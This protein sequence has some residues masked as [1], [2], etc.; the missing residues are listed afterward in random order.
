MKL[1]N[2]IFSNKYY[3]HTHARAHSLNFSIG[4]QDCSKFYYFVEIVHCAEYTDKK[5][6]R[7]HTCACHQLLM[8]LLRLKSFWF[9]NSKLRWRWHDDRYRF[10][11]PF[12]NN[13]TKKKPQLTFFFDKF[14]EI[15]A[16]RPSNTAHCSIFVHFG[17][18][19]QSSNFARAKKNDERQGKMSIISRKSRSTCYLKLMS[20]N[21]HTD[22]PK[23]ESSKRC[24]YV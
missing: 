13:N 15:L 12:F 17:V 16:V 21:R 20:S 4:A 22:T 14:N 6:K 8:K 19:F 24:T 7:A 10:Y 5:K 23:K 2:Q 9:H 11:E 18:K 1:T 3:T